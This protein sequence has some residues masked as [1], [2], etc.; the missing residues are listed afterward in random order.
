LQTQELKEVPGGEPGTFLIRSPAVVDRARAAFRAE[1]RLVERQR[2]ALGVARELRANRSRTHAIRAL[3][4]RRV[5]IE[6]VARAEA[7]L[8]EASEVRSCADVRHVGRIET[9]HR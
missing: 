6:R 8:G 5:D 7:A 1:T 2:A 4:G 9:L 3:R